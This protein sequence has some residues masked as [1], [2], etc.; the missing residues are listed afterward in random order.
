MSR[1]P[2]Q[3]FLG[4]CHCI[5]RALDK[6]KQSLKGLSLTGR[7]EIEVPLGPCCLSRAR[8]GI[9]GLRLQLGLD[10]SG[11]KV[12]ERPFVIVRGEGEV[13]CIMSLCLLPAGK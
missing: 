1:A 4:V 5:G 13:K 3:R 8:S 7:D 12:K 9:Y 2:G 11:A 6:T 10:W